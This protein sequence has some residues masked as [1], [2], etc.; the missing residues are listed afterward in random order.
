M[1]RCV[2]FSE[3]IKNQFTSQRDELHK[4]IIKNLVDSPYALPEAD[5]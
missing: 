3:K 5:R 2:D 1:C 4:Q